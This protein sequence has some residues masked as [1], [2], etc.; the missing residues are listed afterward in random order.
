MERLT[1]SEALEIVHSIH[2]R[3][4]AIPML[5]FLNRPDLIY[6]LIEDIFQDAQW[7]ID[8]YCTVKD[9]K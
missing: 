1:L 8:D 9:E 7:L 3:A 2:N 5:V 4:E 6:T